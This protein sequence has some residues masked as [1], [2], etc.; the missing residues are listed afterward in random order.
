MNILIEG[1]PIEIF[2]DN[3][4]LIDNIFCTCGHLGAEHFFADVT[5]N[6]REV[7]DLRCYYGVFPNECNCEHF[8]PVIDPAV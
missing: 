3:R 7:E 4:N 2:K 6:G 8:E 5:Y 1:K